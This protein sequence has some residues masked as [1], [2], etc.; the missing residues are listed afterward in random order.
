MNNSGLLNGGPTPPHTNNAAPHFG[1][2]S[3]VE[4]C[5]LLGA[6]AGA[7]RGIFGAEFFIAAPESFRRLAAS[8]N[9]ANSENQHAAGHRVDDL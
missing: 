5:G 2:G 1:V 7:N 3:G 9:E 4:R 8:E 6:D